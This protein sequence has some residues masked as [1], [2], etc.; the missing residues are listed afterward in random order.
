MRRSHGMLLASAAAGLI[1]SGAIVARAEEKAGGELVHCAGVNACKGQGQCASAEN[2]CQGMNA[3]KGRA[4]VEM[5]K[6]D[7]EKKSGKIVAPKK[8]N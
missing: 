2:A 3:C 5:S 8:A 1:L 6:A 7:C 4:W